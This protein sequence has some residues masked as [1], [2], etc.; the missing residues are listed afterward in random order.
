MRERST[1]TMCQRL[2]ATGSRSPADIICLDGNSLGPLQHSVRERMAKVADTK[3]GE[4]LIRSWN[5]Y[6]W[7]DL[8]ARAG[9]KIAPLIG[10]AADT[11]T[12]TV[13]TS[14]NILARPTP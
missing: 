9:A 7:L 12:V 11:V 10:A 13:S 6:G 1:V 14:V 2:C 3:W 4:V 5:T 8:P